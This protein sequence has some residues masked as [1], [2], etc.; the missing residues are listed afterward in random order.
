MIFKTLGLMNLMILRSARSSH[1]QIMAG[2]MIALVL[3]G[4]NRCLTVQ[5][6]KKPLHET[7][8]Y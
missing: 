7:D 1:A 4:Y 5:P 3:I 6:K 8:D 2:A